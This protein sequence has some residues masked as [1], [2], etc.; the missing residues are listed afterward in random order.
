MKSCK[1]CKYWSRDEYSGSR[2][3]FRE[4]S[5]LKEEKLMEALAQ[6]IVFSYETHL[7]FGCVHWEPR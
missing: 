6:D 5:K 1:N 7:T 3:E 4:C 2:E